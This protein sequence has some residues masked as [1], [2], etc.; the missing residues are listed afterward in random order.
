MGVPSWVRDAVFYQIFPDRFANGDLE[1]DPPNAQPWGAEPTMWGFQGGDLSGIIQRF[2]YLL[3]L[4][5]NAIYLN[6]IFLSTSNHRYNTMDYY[7]IDPRVGTFQ[8]FHTFLDLAHSNG[9][10]VIL[11]GV[12]NHCG[13]GFFAFQDV[14]ENQEY[15]A[16][17]DWFFI[18]HFPVDA[19]SNVKAR[20]YEAWWGFSSLPKLNTNNEKV[21]RYIFDVAKYWIAQ[22]VDGWRLDVPNEIDDD[23]FWEE[24]RYVVKSTNPDAYLVG[25]IWDGDP[26]WVGSKHFDG[27]INYPLRT[28]IIDVLLGKINV[29]DFHNQLDELLNRFPNEN[30]FAMYLV[31]GTH[32]TERI[33][34]ALGDSVDKTQLAFTFLFSFPGAPGIYYGDEIGIKGGKDPECRKAFPWDESQWNKSLRSWVQSLIQMRKEHIA[35]RWGDFNALVVDDERK[36]YAFSRHFDESKCAVIMNLSDVDKQIRLPV[37]SLWNDGNIVHDYFIEEGYLVADGAVHIRLKPW[38]S[39]ILVT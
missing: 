11:D 8:E 31:V 32:D 30:V 7:K 38:Q 1:N 6:P 33:L 10:R 12:F 17:K 15:S 21:R 22:G 28:S 25:E 29:S 4:G 26:R 13:R 37:E 19:Y 3:D 34:S 9:V 35:M 24:F 20:D 36:V 16:Y 5:I 27:L 2:D 39:I 18:H 23:S 14:L